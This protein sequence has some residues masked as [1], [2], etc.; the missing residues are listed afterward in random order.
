MRVSGILMQLTV[1]DV[2]K[3]LK[4]SE[5]TIYRWIK[6]GKLP[7]YRVSDQY[8]F[9]RPELLEWATARRVGISPEVLTEPRMDDAT[10][11]SL[12]D[13]IKTGGIY[14]RIDGKDKRASLRSLV[15]VMKLPDEV[16]RDALLAA[17]LARE[18][19]AST[20]IGQGVAI[21]HVRGPVV[22]HVE[23]PIL[24]LG[25][26]SEPIDFDAIDKKPVGALF[27]LIC[28]TIRTHLH[29][30]SRLSYVLQQESFMALIQQQ[31]LREAIVQELGQ[32]EAPLEDNLS[33]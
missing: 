18:E 13:A 23:K 1:R 12:L 10:P 19:L 29:L 9:S 3:L 2:S 20:G 6:S 4:V 11:A 15:E 25:F 5:K 16:D 30:L 26:L 22:L 17:L 7:A 28:P 32:I 21:P 31:T 33:S 14:Y 8:R 24:S 27:F